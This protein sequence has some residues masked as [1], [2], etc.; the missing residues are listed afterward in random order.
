MMHSHL[1]TDSTGRA[2]SSLSSGTFV[3][4]VARARRLIRALDGFG[5]AAAVKIYDWGNEAMG[6]IREKIHYD[7]LRYLV[8]NP[9]AQDTLKGV[10]EWWLAEQ[11]GRPNIAL[12]EEAL[13]GLVREGLVLARSS[14]DTR[15]YYQVNRRRLKE[16]SALLEEARKRGL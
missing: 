2:I 14:N 6:E 11:S 15:T 4:S 16:I 8:E 5:F 13:S 1:A 10:T 9:D 12:V 3:I 7:I